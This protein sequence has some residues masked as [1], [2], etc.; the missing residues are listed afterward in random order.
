MGLC[1][2]ALWISD[3]QS[4]WL[5]EKVKVANNIDFVLN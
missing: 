3:G 2:K 5:G 4:S 1:E